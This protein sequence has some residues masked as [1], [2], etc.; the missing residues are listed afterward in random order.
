MPEISVVPTREVEKISH[1][2]GMLPD[3]YIG[4]IEKTLIPY[5]LRYQD[6]NG[7]FLH[8][9]KITRD[10]GSSFS[11]H[12]VESECDELPKII[13]SEYTKKGVKRF[14]AYT[15]DLDL[16]KLQNDKKYL[17][18]FSEVLCSKSRLEEKKQ[19]SLRNNNNE[20]IYL[21]GLKYDND[22]NKYIKIAKRYKEVEREIDLKRGKTPKVNFMVKP[23]TENNAF[24]GDITE[25]FKRKKN[26]DVMSFN[27]FEE[28]DDDDEFN[29]IDSTTMISR[30]PVKKV[31]QTVNPQN[32]KNALI[33]NIT[34]HLVN[35]DSEQLKRIAK[36]L[37]I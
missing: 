26:I 10:D 14:Y 4:G 20:Y 7:K 9:L 1:D 31:A 30:K 35:L 29:F 5:D 2:Q 12:E 28:D 33:G 8:D 17:Y 3:R 19:I 16:V 36:Q 24:I 25:Q 11:I 34:G 21:G 6:L 23:K 18:A 32:E 15:H 37:G 27:S 13:I 22:A